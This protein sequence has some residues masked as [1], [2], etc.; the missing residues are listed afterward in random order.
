MT[1]PI[2]KR[3]R[4]FQP[5]HKHHPYWWASHGIKGRG[6]K[7]LKEIFETKADALKALEEVTH[8]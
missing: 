4:Q 1:R 2:Q 8:G 6:H 5:W 7:R 3:A